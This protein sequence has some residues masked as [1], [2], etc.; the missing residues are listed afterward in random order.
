MTP[1]L[2]GNVFLGLP[3]LQ[4]IAAAGE[5]LRGHGYTVTPP[6]LALD[7][8]SIGDLCRRFGLAHA[9]I[10][11]RLHHPSCPRTFRRLGPHGRIVAI[12]LSP[13][14]AAWLARPKQPGRKLAA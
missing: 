14:L 1:K 8:H 7:E 12:S 11:K 5:F 6:G 10:H 13:E 4:A 9:T 3:T 2:A